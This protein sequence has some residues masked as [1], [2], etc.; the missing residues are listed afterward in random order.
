M[1]RCGDNDT[2]RVHGKVYVKNAVCEIK[3]DLYQG[4]TD[5]KTLEKKFGTDA[6]CDLIMLFLE[7]IER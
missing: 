6:I 3:V 1:R 4:A 2:V 5:E 7:H